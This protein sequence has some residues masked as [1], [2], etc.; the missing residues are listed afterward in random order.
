MKKI[1]LALIAIL[2]ITC[3]E[4]EE[5]W[6]FFDLWKGP[7]DYGQV[8]AMRNNVLWEASAYFGTDPSKPNHF[9]LEFI[10]FYPDSIVAETFSI[11]RIPKQVGEFHVLNFPPPKYDSLSSLYLLK[12]D[13]APLEWYYSQTYENRENKVWINEINTIAGIISG[14]F[15]I[16][17]RKD[18]SNDVTKFPNV[19]RF[20]N[21]VFKVDFRP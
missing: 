12:H 16:T 9:E 8:Q 7:Q 3:C 18:T 1:T 2:L 5:I 11:G 4:K 14:G 19:V 21:G 15:D 17:F 20:K 6:P 13:D 10:A